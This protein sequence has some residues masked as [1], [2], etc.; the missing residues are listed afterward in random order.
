MIS[1]INSMVK[2]NVL[3]IRPSLPH[4]TPSPDVY[5]FSLSKDRFELFVRGS[6]WPRSLDEIDLISILQTHAKG[7]T[8]AW[9]ALLLVV[10]V[11]PSVL[12]TLNESRKQRAGVSA[13]EVARGWGTSPWIAREKLYLVFEVYSAFVCA[14]T[15]SYAVPGSACDSGY[16]SQKLNRVWEYPTGL[17][18]NIRYISKL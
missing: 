1:R 13:L 5:L 2:N 12:L 15:V 16:N 8:L 18:I 14:N 9:Q 7:R 17:G 4:P 3:I 11:C 10:Y 6:P